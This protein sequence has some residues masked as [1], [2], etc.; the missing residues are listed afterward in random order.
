MDSADVVEVV[1]DV[2]IYTTTTRRGGLS[3]WGKVP[4]WSTLAKGHHARK[5]EQHG[6]DNHPLMRDRRNRALATPFGNERRGVPV[7]TVHWVGQWRG[8]KANEQLWYNLPP[9]NGR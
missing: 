6:R 3:Y 9:R 5:T 1:S 4:S 2:A 7:D 8:V